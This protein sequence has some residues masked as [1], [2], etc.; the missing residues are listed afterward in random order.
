M[1]RYTHGLISDDTFK[2]RNVSQIRNRLKDTF[3]VDRVCFINNKI[4]W[5]GPGYCYHVHV[6]LNGCMQLRSTYVHVCTM[7]KGR[8]SLNNESSIYGLYSIS[9]HFGSIAATV[10]LLVLVH[11]LIL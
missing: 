7:Q 2:I 9:A 1:N 5:G 4:M 10:D 11:Q 8:P 6:P 3:W